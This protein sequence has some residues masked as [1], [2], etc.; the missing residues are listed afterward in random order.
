MDAERFDGLIAL[1]SRGQSRRAAVRNV[2]AG[3]VAIG[4]IA[5]RGERGHAGKAA[6]RRRRRRRRCLEGL[7]RAV[8]FLLLRHQGRDPLRR[9][10]RGHL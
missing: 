10:Q 7:R 3:V 2:L 5:S 6:K 9:W 8:R 1:L 4:G